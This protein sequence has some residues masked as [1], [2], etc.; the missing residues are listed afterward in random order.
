[1]AIPLS[2]TGLKLLLLEG[3]SSSSAESRR[4]I[5]DTPYSLFGM[6]VDLVGT[7]SHAGLT[8][9]TLYGSACGSTHVATTDAITLCSWS[10]NSGVTKFSSTDGQRFPIN[11]IWAGVTDAATSATA[12]INVWVAALP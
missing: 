12:N 11:Q 8:A 6:T 1:M 10:T 5:F 7:S 3:A 4:Y 2:G 9:A